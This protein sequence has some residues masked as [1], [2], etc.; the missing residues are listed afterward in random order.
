[1]PA[2]ATITYAELLEAI[3]PRNSVTLA[4]VQAISNAAAASCLAGECTADEAAAVIEFAADCYKQSLA[5]S[6]LDDFLAN[7]RARSRR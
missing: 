3:R 7:A 4:D 6:L 5:Q 2:D 1:M